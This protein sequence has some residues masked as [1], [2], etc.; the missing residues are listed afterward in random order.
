MPDKTSQNEDS[1]IVP[2]HQKEDSLPRGI[3][4]RARINLIL[5]RKMK[6]EWRK[7]A[8][9]LHLSLSQLI[10][11]AVEDFQNNLIKKESIPN[12]GIVLENGQVDNPKLRAD[13]NLMKKRIKGMIKIQKSIPIKKLA[14]TLEISEEKAERIIYELAA[15]EKIKGDMDGDVFRFSNDIETT[16]SS[17]SN[18]IEKL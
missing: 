2:N 11:Q 16:I 9:T 5:P 7:L 13:K 4:Q 14:L 10:R 12:N 15:E 6:I 17:L 18:L 3:M 8:Q 1:N